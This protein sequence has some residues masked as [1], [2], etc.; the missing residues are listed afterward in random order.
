MSGAGDTLRLCGSGCGSAIIE[1]EVVVVAIVEVSE[2]A[3]EPALGIAIV[4][5]AVDGVEFWELALEQTVSNFD[6]LWQEFLELFADSV[7]LVEPAGFVV[8]EVALGISRAVSDLDRDGQT[9][10][11]YFASV[12]SL[13]EQ[14][15][16]GLASGRRT[17]DRFC[18]GCAHEVLVEVANG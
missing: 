10:F 5:E 13:F 7:F 4:S 3:L 8:C 9:F 11:A 14:D 16:L 1:V 6:R 2:V 17:C 15:G 12:F 18:V